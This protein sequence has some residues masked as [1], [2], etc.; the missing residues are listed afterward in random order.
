MYSRQGGLSLPQS[1]HGNE[2]PTS[3]R[4]VRVFGIMFVFCAL[5]ALVSTH[6]VSS[7]RLAHSELSLSR[8]APY[9]EYCETR[10]IGEKETWNFHK[11]VISYALFLPSHHETLPDW[12]MNGMTANT[13][14]AKLYYPDWVLR[15]YTLNLSNSAIESLL[16]LSDRI[17]V[18]RCHNHTLL[19]QPYESIPASR[20]PTARKMI[21][22]FLA[23]D[24]P[25]VAVAIVRDADSRFSVR[26]LLA[27]NQWLSSEQY[28]HCMRDHPFHLQPVMGGMFGMKRG[29]SQTTTMTQLIHQALQD[30]PH[31]A[32]SGVEYDQAFL[33]NYLWP[34]VKTSALC[35]DSDLQRCRNKGA[36]VCM[37][38]PLG[39]SNIEQEY[40]VGAAFQ[41]DEWNRT[42]T[43]TIECN[44]E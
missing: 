30:F 25:T 4:G 6:L 9:G 5:L 31:K 2:A 32:I 8:E 14:V 21:P 23:I 13:E 11:K 27:V 1:S 3:R 22:R 18:V 12:L 10:P 38:F 33:A 29:W 42:H 41:A 17:E 15:V 20:K 26:E 35:H 34:V 7:R 36:A 39:P 44:L 16:Q 40:F 37:Q 43:C 24:D 19:N 28:F